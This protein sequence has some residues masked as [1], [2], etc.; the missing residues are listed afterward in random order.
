MKSF[1][2]S[3]LKPIEAEITSHLAYN[4]YSDYPPAVRWT[5]RID[6]A[7]L[8]LGPDAA[9]P[10]IET[11]VDS[12]ILLAGLELNIRDWR[13]LSGEFTW[14]GEHQDGS[15]CVTSAH[16]PVDARKLVLTRKEGALFDLDA[17]M[18]FC[19]EFEG[20]GYTD[21]TTRIVCPARY[22]G[23]RFCVPTWNEPAKVKFPKGWKV[24]SA[25]PQWSDDEILDF[26][27]RYADLTPFASVEVTEGNYLEAKP[28]PA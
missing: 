19:F 5:V 3:R 8:S 15:F 28:D 10:E 18:D 6:I 7:P 22:S 26:V 21:E 24:P 12:S 23:F 11:E 2:F 14:F 1:P 4:P 17:T 13:E 16:N 25:E 20:A 27:R 9:A